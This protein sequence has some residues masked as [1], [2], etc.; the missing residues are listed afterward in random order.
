VLHRIQTGV[1]VIDNFVWNAFS[2]LVELGSLEGEKLLGH[3][4]FFSFLVFFRDNFKKRTLVCF[5]CESFLFFENT[6]LII[7][8]EQKKHARE[9]LIFVNTDSLDSL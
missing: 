8:R 2:C 1:G 6:Q 4:F 3:D 9:K 7:R 5:G